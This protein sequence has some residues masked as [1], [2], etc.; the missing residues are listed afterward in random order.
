VIEQIKALVTARKLQGIA[1]VKD[2]TD[3]STNGTRLVIEVK[4]GF[5]PEALLEQLYKLTKME[6]NF[7]INA[8]ALVDGQPRTLTLRDLLTVYLE[9]RYEVTRRRTEFA[10]RKAA[11]RL[12]LVEGLLV[13]IL[14]ID[15]VIALIR[16]SDDTAA[17]RARLR[18][19]FEL[20][21]LQANYILEMPLRRLT[22]FST[23]EL[24][25]ERDALTT[26]I[27]DLTAILEDRDRLRGLVGDDLAEMARTHG[28]PRRTI[29]LASSGVVTTAAAPLEVPDDPCWVLLSSAGLL[30]RTSH[31][32]P[33]PAA[34][35]RTPHDVVTSSVLTTARGELGL[36]TSAGRLVKI[37]ALDLPTVP[38]TAN[39]PNLQ[40]GTHVSELV[41]L[42]A[43][44]Q[45]LALTTLTPD[46]PGLALGTAGGVVKRVHAE[47]LA[48]EA[49]EVIRLEPGDRVVGAVELPPGEAELVFISSDAQLLHFPA[50]VVRPQGRSGGG[51]A[52]IKLA[53]G[54]R[55]VFFGAVPL[56]AGAPAQPGDVV[57]VTVAGSSAALPGTDAGTVKVTPFTEYPGKG[58]ATGGVR[59]H[60]FLR[61]EDVLLLGW[62]GPAPAMAAAASGAPVELPAPDGRR[63]GSGVALGQPVAAVASPAAASWPTAVAQP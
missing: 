44:E 27:S 58:R 53:P 3:L 36:V 48:K 62:A 57:V 11:D 7:A 43:D 23:L 49:W 14:D 50:S 17:A 2:L 20:S 22:R 52:G 38:T 28:T 61:G 9:H 56:T 5:H 25:T 30:A 32:E 54:A 60:R 33:L 34:G 37:T 40:G 26:Q 6:D 47:L 39:A 31:A 1:D 12:H 42:A 63:D 18:E 55:A 4:N 29:L 10:R 41:T 15:D 19:A 8:V 16:S 59:C 45:P 35:D 46:S 13:A 21:E 24:E 51:M